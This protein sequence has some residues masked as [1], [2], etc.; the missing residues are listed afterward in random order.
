MLTCVCLQRG[1][2]ETKDFQ[3]HKSLAMCDVES[4]ESNRSPTSVKCPLCVC[5]D[6]G[7]GVTNS[8]SK[9]YFFLLRFPKNM[10]NK[11]IVRIVLKPKPLVRASADCYVVI[12]DVYWL[13][14]K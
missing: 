7:G 2:G 13:S 14:N 4:V 8:N 10:S 12:V 11:G 6:A 9:T 1:S 3:G 5:C